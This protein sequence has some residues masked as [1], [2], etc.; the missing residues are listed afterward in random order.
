MKDKTQQAGD[1]SSKSKEDSTPRPVVR[2]WLILERFGL[3]FLAVFF[4]C[5]FLISLLG[6]LRLSAGSALSWWTDILKRLFGVG[7]YY[8][9]FLFGLIGFLSLRRHFRALP[10][11]S[12]LQLLA[13]EGLTFSLV[14]LLDLF[15]GHNSTYANAGRFG[16]TIGWGLNEIIPDQARIVNWIFSIL[17]TSVLFLYGFGLHRKLIPAI[18]RW[19]GI[20]KDDNLPLRN[21]PISAVNEPVDTDKPVEAV[22]ISQQNSDSYMRDDRLPPLNLLQNDTTHPISEEKIQETAIR[23]EHSLAEFG[24]TA[25]VVGYRAGPAIT[26]YAVE[27]GYVEKEGNEG[28]IVKQK[29]RVSQIAT[30]AK[31]LT[32]ALSAERLRIEAPVP[33]RSYIGIE[34]P[35]PGN[36]TVRLRPILESEPFQRLGS[37]LSIALGRDV[38]GQPVVADLAR[39]PHLLIAGTTG[40]GKSV[41]IVSL[42]TC[43]IMNNSPTDLRMV[44]IDPKMVE[45]VKFNGL[46]HLLGEVETQQVRMLAALQWAIAEMDNRYRIFEAAH[47]RDLDVHNRKM[48]RKKQPTL[49]R[50]VILIDELADLMMSRPDQTEFSLVRLAQ[51]ARATGIHLVVA[52]QRPSK[53]VVTGLIKANFPARISFNVASSID[54]RV[55]LDT[56]GAETLLGKGDMLF[57]NPE[58][59]IPQRAQGAMVSDAEVRKLTAFWQKMAPP[60]MEEKTPWEDITQDEPEEISDDLLEKAID[61]VRRARHASASLLQRRLRIGYPRAARLMDELEEMGVVG[62][63]QVG[64]KER[65]VLTPYGLQ[66]PRDDE[67]DDILS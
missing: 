53:E 61:V 6:L 50:I 29:V 65:E 9:I 48:Q 52:T 45:L 1:R 60:S 4:F 44:M 46:P 19:L 7:S 12:F 11:L 62:Q 38:S 55:I 49:P 40:S 39:M 28:E 58:V 54:S 37:Q 2:T 16:G 23:I 47:S 25:R 18:E 21:R 20:G 43:L 33:G 26:Q 24:I 51:M 14:A 34:I 56:T 27:P 32:L 41:C 13:L 31:D 30:L 17:L 63:A 3:D 15:G 36:S 10:W 64:G 59:G 67:A 57:L 42:A 22:A 35:N 66:K 8:A 5:L